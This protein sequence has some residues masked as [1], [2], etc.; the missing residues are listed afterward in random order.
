MMVDFVW[1]GLPLQQA[2]QI[3]YKKNTF[4]LNCTQN[5]IVKLLCLRQSMKYKQCPLRLKLMRRERSGQPDLK[6]IQGQL[7]VKQ[8]GQGQGQYII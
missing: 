8:I 7:K 1:I 5:L 4:R 3:S 2:Q 6:A